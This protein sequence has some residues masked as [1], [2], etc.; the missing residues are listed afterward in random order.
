MQSKDDGVEETQCTAKGWSFHV[1][2]RDAGLNIKSGYDIEL[3][4]VPIQTRVT[5]YATQYND[6]ISELA[7]TMKYILTFQAPQL[8]VTKP[9]NLQ[10]DAFLNSC[11]GDVRLMDDRSRPPQLISPSLYAGLCLKPA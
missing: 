1:L 8:S 2:N 11:I 6:Q 7:N 4:S 9:I 5:I 3:Q 10:L